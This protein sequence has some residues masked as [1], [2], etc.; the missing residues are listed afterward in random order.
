MF[1]H[2][3]FGAVDQTFWLFLQRSF[4][5]KSALQSA[6]CSAG[7]AAVKLQECLF[8][9]QRCGQG[10]RPGGRSQMWALCL[11]P[12]G[13][14]SRDV[15]YDA[16]ESVIGSL[17]SKWWMSCAEHV[18]HH[19]A[20]TPHLCRRSLQEDWSCSLCWFMHSP[21]I[22]QD[23]LFS[24]CHLCCHSGPGLPAAV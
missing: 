3:F 22:H 4:C 19:T 21:E 24:S 15:I 6:S 9:W 13:F 7:S 23:L 5:F 2:H 11:R 18:I 8:P 1:Y 17:E 12:P 10:Q 16:N 20:A 14:P